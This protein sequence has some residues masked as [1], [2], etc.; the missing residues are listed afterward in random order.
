MSLIEYLAH[1]E[2]KKYT[3]EVLKTYAVPIRKNLGQNFVVDKKLIDLMLE[4]AKIQS[5]D[6][7]VEVGPG[8]GTL[9]YYILPQCSSIYSYEIDPLLASIIRKEFIDYSEKFHVISKDFLEDDIISHDKL[10]S[11]LPYNISSPFIKKITQLPNPPHVI[12]ITLQKEFANHLCARPGSSA[13]SKIS[14]YAS[15]F[16][17]FEKLATFSPTS[18]FP[19]PRVESTII[20]GEKIVTSE[21]VQSSFFQI[22][23]T[24][25]FCRKHK[26]VK[27]NL[28]GYFKYIFKDDW[29]KLNQETGDLIFRNDQ[30]VNLTKE[31]I[32]EL[33]HEVAKITEKR[34][35]KL[36]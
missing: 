16:Y 18:F 27:N 35:Q 30:P 3:V 29:R 1:N 33:Y 36:Y 10:V 14:V 8:I 15:Y 17:E 6:V 25:L 9:S 5:K 26:K 34:D 13:Y 32:L 20:R 24:H 28:K 2:L 22:F 11:N 21:V 12:V 23:L 4:G 19:K 7:I 31:E